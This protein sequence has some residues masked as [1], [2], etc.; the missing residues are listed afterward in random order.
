MQFYLLLGFGALSLAFLLM[1]SV[2]FLAI[3]KKISDLTDRIE[4]H[5]KKIYTKAQSGKGL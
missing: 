2:Q 4:F 5:V 1:L 3:E